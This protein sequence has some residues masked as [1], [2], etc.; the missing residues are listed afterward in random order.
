MCQERR[1]FAQG[2]G[3][4]RKLP[5]RQASGP[6]N[7]TCGPTHRPMNEALYVSASFDRRTVMGPT[8]RTRS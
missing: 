4:H 2:S 8:S 6:A 7:P 5:E 1:M 3:G